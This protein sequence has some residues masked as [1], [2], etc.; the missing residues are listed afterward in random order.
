MM[1]ALP[2]AD[3][4]ALPLFLA[5]QAVASCRGAGKAGMVVIR[6]VL[7]GSGGCAARRAALERPL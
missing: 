2:C 4:S 3:H 5:L 6:A 1:A 7:A